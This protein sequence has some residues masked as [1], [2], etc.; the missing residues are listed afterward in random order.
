[1]AATG[2]RQA[3]RSKRNSKSETDNR[4]RTFGNHKI[5]DI[6]W[7]LFRYGVIAQRE[8]TTGYWMAWAGPNDG[9]YTIIK[10]SVDASFDTKRQALDALME[11]I[12]NDLVESIPLED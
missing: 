7:Q 11:V 5:H 4:V 1:M 9:K 2:T 12:R 6:A 10:Y 8:P 3:S